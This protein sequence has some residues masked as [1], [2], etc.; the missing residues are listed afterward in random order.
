MIQQLANLNYFF[1]RKHFCFMPST[2]HKTDI[3]F[4]MRFWQPRRIKRIRPGNEIIQALAIVGNF[5]PFYSFKI[6]V[7][8][9][10]TGQTVFFKIYQQPLFEVEFWKST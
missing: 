6:A 7:N 3:F 8:N 9:M 10:H 1:C 5:N 2:N 4:T